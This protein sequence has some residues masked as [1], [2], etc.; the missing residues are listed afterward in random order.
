VRSALLLTGGSFL[1]TVLVQAW[2]LQQS[3]PRDIKAASP[4]Y[5]QR[6]WA[7]VTLPIFASNTIYL[8]FSRVDVVMVG[9]LRS[10]RDAGIYAVAMRAG[11]VANILETAMASTLAPR[12][13]RLYWSGRRDEVQDVT[14]KA[15]YWLFLPTLLLTVVLGVLA[16]P[17]LSLF[18]SE[19]KTGAD[20]LIIIA[21]GQLVSVSSG[22]VGWLMN[23]TGH[24]NVTTVVYAIVA[25]L[26]MAGY[27]TLIPWLGITGAALANAGAVVVRNV[28][29]NVLVRR[30]LGYSISV[31]RAFRR[32]F[33]T[34]SAR[35]GAGRRSAGG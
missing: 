33:C 27:L 4:T 9:L 35:N 15:V 19:F 23:M 6:E 18:G 3:L 17:I 29:L 1:V 28:A 26:T 10:P 13:S 30:R 31:L 25:A 5:A 2:W 22:A 7:K 8:M 20:V 12:I 24:Q 32:R 34:S 16:H 21:I 14:L 11:T